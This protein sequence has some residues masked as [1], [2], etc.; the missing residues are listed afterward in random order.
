M[1]RQDVA[2]VD[3]LR[4]EGFTVAVCYCGAHVLFAGCDVCGYELPARRAQRTADE[5]EDWK[6]A[7]HAAS[8]RR[9]R[10]A[11]LRKMRRNRQKLTTE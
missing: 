5:L 3:R 10:R 11:Q 7:G 8:V 2:V 6:R 1:K 9:R 4:A